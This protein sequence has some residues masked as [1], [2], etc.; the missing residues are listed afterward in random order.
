MTKIWNACWN[1]RQYQYQREFPKCTLIGKSDNKIIEVWIKKISLNYHHH[2][3]LWHALT[4]S[5]S[6]LTRGHN[7]ACDLTTRTIFPLYVPCM[8]PWYK[9]NGLLVSWV[10]PKYPNSSPTHSTQTILPLIHLE[11]HSFFDCCS[12]TPFLTPKISTSEFTFIVQMGKDFQLLFF[13]RKLEFCLNPNKAGLFEGSF[14]W[15]EVGGGSKKN[16]PNINITLF[17]C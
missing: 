2:N 15:W 3:L 8:F 10:I 17:D 5:Y 7:H 14:F 11:Y 13:N 9:Y 12:I 4:S 6:S 16:L 1:Y